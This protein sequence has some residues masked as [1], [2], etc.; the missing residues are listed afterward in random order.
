MWLTDGVINEQASV[1]QLLG[2][3][4]GGA[5]LSGYEGQALPASTYAGKDKAAVP[6]S[7]DSPLL[8]G[9]GLVLLTAFGILGASGSVRVGKARAAASIG[10]K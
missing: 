10:D 3:N 1:S 6:W 9:A 5:R 8:W 4:P 7:L 2:M